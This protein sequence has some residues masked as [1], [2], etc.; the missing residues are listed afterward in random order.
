MCQ[1]GIMCR[2]SVVKFLFN[3]I[4]NYNNKSNRHRIRLTSSGSILCNIL[5]LITYE[6]GLIIKT[7][8]FFIYTNV[9]RNNSTAKILQYVRV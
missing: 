5:L 7:F 4:V 6:R 3:I 1:R 8:D 2:G 9:G